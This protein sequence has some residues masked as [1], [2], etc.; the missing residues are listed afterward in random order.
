MTSVLP[1]SKSKWSEGFIFEE[2]AM[3]K[4]LG[5]V[6]LLVVLFSSFAMP[7]LAS[8]GG[9]GVHFGPY[10]LSDEDMVTGDLVVFG[11]VDLGEGSIF[12]GDLAAFGE[13]TVEEDAIIT[14]D[15]VCFGATDVAGVVEGNVFAA[16]SIYLAET[17][18]IEGDVSAIGGIS[19]AEGALVEGQVSPMDGDDFDWD[20][21]FV[22]PFVFSPSSPRPMWHG[23]LWKLTR[24][25]FMVVVLAIFSLIFAAVWP[26][27]V[28]RVGQVIVDEPL[29]SFGVGALVLLIA[30]VLTLGLTLTVCLIPFA[31]LVGIVVGIGVILGWVSLGA[32]LGRRLLRDLFKASA[33]TP[34]GS[35]ALGTTLITLLAVML[36]LISGCLYTL[37]IF[38]L[39]GLVAGAVTLTRFG[40]MPYATRGTVP[41]SPAADSTSSEAP[42]A[43]ALPTEQPPHLPE[44]LQS[45]PEE[46]ASDDPE[47]QEDTPS[48]E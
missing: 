5:A 30:F 36:N 27:Q 13:V 19:Q 41:Q 28:E 34:L 7:V 45:P 44:E 15:L 20:V 1:A 39:F 2:V 40:T 23:V 43:P 9:G 16:G 3:L 48:T 26:K 25:I 6:C 17:A 11:P 4:R 38:P 12:D 24:A 42:L 47:P 46:T 31:L 29:P 18:E 8:Q 37:L 32:L 14:G 35:A 33:I 22:G 21:P 10:S